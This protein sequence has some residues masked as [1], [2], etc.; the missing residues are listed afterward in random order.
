MPS[1]DAKFQA[2]TPP[3]RPQSVPG[4]PSSV[5][6]SNSFEASCPAL[7]NN[8]SRTSPRSTSLSSSLDEVHGDHYKSN[9]VDRVGIFTHDE[10]EKSPEWVPQLPYNEILFCT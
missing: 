5:A 2:F 1:N 8:A 4:R 7:P 9:D 10:I 6:S 3:M